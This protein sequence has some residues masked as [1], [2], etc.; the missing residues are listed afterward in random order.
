MNTTA[1]R[2]LM[3]A[4]VVAVCAAGVPAAEPGH[5]IESCVSQQGVIRFDA[6][7]QH[8]VLEP[9]DQMRVQAEMEQRYPVLAR[10][11]FPVSK[12]M[13]WH[14]KSGETVFITLLQHPSKPGEACFTAT[15]AA[16]R[17]AGIDTLRRKYLRPELQI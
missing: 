1:A 8:V 15:F 2:S 6:I 12:I 3:G 16:A 13:L 4:G 17:F 7:D 10:H 5:S 14:K 9:D 11:G